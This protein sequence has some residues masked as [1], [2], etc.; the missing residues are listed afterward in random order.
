MPVTSEDEWAKAVEA[1]RTA[2]GPERDTDGEPGITNEETAHDWI[3][4]LLPKVSMDWLTDISVSIG[5]TTRY[6]SKITRARAILKIMHQN[7]ATGG[8]VAK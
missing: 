2:C 4:C 5:D 1:F 3:R 6:S 8:E 7:A